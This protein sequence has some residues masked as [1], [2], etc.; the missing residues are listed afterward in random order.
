MVHVAVTFNGTNYKL[1]IDGISVQTT[2]SG[3]NPIL[4]N[5]T[6]CILGAMDQSG[7]PL[8][9]LTDGWMNFAFGKWN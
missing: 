5:S 4:N 1:Y 8:T 2:V 9:I 6:N 7:I 3:V